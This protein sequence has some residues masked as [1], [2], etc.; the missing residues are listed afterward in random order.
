MGEGAPKPSPGAAHL[1]LSLGMGGGGGGGGAAARRAAEE[2]EAEHERDGSGDGDGGDDGDGDGDG[3]DGG[4]V[5]GGGGGGS[6]SRPDESGGRARKAATAAAAGGGGGGRAKR[7]AGSYCREAHSLR[8]LCSSF[9]AAFP[10]G[11]VVA[12]VPSTAAQLGASPRRLYDLL[13]VLETLK[14]VAKTGGGGVRVVGWDALGGT[15]AELAS[16]PPPDAASSSL[17][18][19]TVR[20]VRA[21]SAT[22][23]GSEH[24]W[25]KAR[26]TEKKIES[27]TLC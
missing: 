5:S 25:E 23:K 6:E 3:G 8:A 15:I 10:P 9:S 12:N 2:E 13:S 21:F 19:L 27:I 1:L 14:G 26:K 24:T 20:F 4:G 7:P 22:Q 11:S 18:A 17:A 16:S